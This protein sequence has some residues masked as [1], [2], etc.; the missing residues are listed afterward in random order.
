MIAA[1]YARKSF[2]GTPLRAR[3]RRVLDDAAVTDCVP[4]V[5]RRRIE[6]VFGV[7][8]AALPVEGLILPPSPRLDR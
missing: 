4:I 5:T 8:P 2:V 3:P 7:P 1:V 6:R